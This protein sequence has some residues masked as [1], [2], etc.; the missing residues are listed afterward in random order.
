MQ[1][2][3]ISVSG[4]LSACL[5]AHISQTQSIFHQVFCTCCLWP[6]LGPP[7]TAMRYVMYLRFC[8]RRHKMFSISHNATKRTESKTTRIFRPVRQV[9]A[10]GAKS[11]FSNCVLSWFQP[12][13]CTRGLPAIVE[14][15]GA[16]LQFH[17]C[18]KAVRHCR[19]SVSR[20]F[21]DDIPR[22]S[23]TNREVVADRRLQKQLSASLCRRVTYTV[24]H[25]VSLRCILFRQYIHAV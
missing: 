25:Q 22:L 12:T 11:A 3:A 1:N 4:R 13:S 14:V 9:A 5:S 16:I 8:G 24:A 23:I 2:I 7:L 18:A 20:Y 10:P 21:C 17:H 19:I 6:W 15:I